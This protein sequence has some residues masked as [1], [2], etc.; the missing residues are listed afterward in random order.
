L[1]VNGLIAEWA[2]FS[3]LIDANIIQKNVSTKEIDKKYLQKIAFLNQIHFKCRPVGDFENLRIISRI[4]RI[5]AGGNTKK[6][7][8]YESYRGRQ[9]P[10]VGGTL[11]KVPG[12]AHVPLRLSRKRL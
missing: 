6:T 7:E 2:D 12:G 4:F 11:Q 10:A 8:G 1:I 9:D 5:F 3:R